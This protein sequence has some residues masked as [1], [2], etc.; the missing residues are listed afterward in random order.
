MLRPALLGLALV[1][2]G[3]AADRA[4]DLRILRAL[5]QGDAGP[6]AVI[7]V[8][9]DR[10]I[11]ASL[12][13]VTAD[14]T[15]ILHI[16]PMVSGLAEWRDPVTLQFTPSAPLAA[17]TSYH[18]TIDTGFRAMDG[19]RLA[20]PYS[21][22]FR[23]RGPQLLAGIPAGPGRYGSNVTSLL[24]APS[25]SFYLV[26]GR[27]ISP[28]LI[29]R[30]TWF[31]TDRSCATGRQVIRS[32]FITT[33]AIDAKDRWEFREAGGYERD[34][35]ADS[36]RRV[37]VIQ[38]ATPLPLNCSIGLVAPP[39]FD[40]DGAELPG[41]YPFN[42][43]GPFTLGACG[44][45]CDAGPVGPIAINFSTPVRGAD[46]QRHVTV[47][48]ATPVAVDDTADVRTR[49]QITTDPLRP[50][51]GY[52]IVADTGLRDVFGQR[53]SG[54]PVTTAVTTGYSPSLEYDGGRMLVERN[55]Y[56]TL[57]VR[58]VNLDTLFLDARP[59]P[60][61]LYAE[62]LRRGPW[63]WSG[64]WNSL[65][66]SAG[67]RAV[68][69]HGDRD[70]MMITGLALPLSDA[71]RPGTA[72]AWAVKV[73]GNVP[74]EKVPNAWGGASVALVQ[75]TDLAVTSRAGGTEATI[76]VTGA[77]DGKPRTGARVEVHNGAG[78]LLAQGV[79]DSS[80]I[81]RFTGLRG[82]EAGAA[83]GEGDDGDCEEDCGG[84]GPA[85]GAYVA[86]RLGA[87]RALL[88]VNE[89]AYDLS[90]W[91][92][93][94]YSAY[95]IAKQQVAAAVFTER[96]IYRPGEPVYAKAIVRTGLLGSLTTPAG[97]SVKL[98]FNDR[99]GGVLRSTVFRL[100]EFGTASDS[101][102]LPADAKLGSYS[103]SAS[104]YRQG[105]WQEAGADQYR[106]AEYRAPEFVVAVA[107][108]TAARFPGDSTRTTVEARYLF[109]APMGRA[110]VHWTASLTPSWFGAEQI[111][112]LGDGWYL[113]A[114]GYWWEDDQPNGPNTTVT[115]EGS[116][117]LDATGHLTIRAPVGAP[118]KGH[119]GMFTVEATVTDVNRRSVAASSRVM[120]HPASFY[121]AAK[122]TGD[123]FWTGGTP[124]RIDVLAVRPDGRKVGG[125]AVQGT[126]IRRE[127]HQV[128][129]TRYGYSEVTGEWVE[130]TVARCALQT[131]ETP[132]SCA[133]TPS[134]G[135]SYIV[136]FTAKDAG[137]RD[138]ETSFYR[139]A[140]G[141]GWV[142]WNDENR[143]KLDIIPDKERYAPGDTATLLIASP[144]TNAEAWFTVEREG[145]IEQRRFR[146][147]DGATRIR[148]P[149]TERHSPNVFVSVVVVRGRSG[150]PGTL[151]D[152]G[153]P[154]LR[155]GYAQLRV[156][157][158]V[159]RLTVSVDPGRPE[160]R[161]GDTASVKVAVRSGQNGVRSEVTLWAVDEGVL[162][163]TGFK[164][165]D[166]LDRIY[167][168]RGLGLTLSSGLVNVAPQVLQEVSRQLKGLRNAGQG[169]GRE[170]ADVLR[171]KFQTTAFFLG[172][173]V[174][175]AD[176]KGSARVKL[177]DN[178]TTFRVMA[179]AVTTGDRYG[180]GE[181]PLLVTRPLLARPSLPRFF[182]P[183]DQF[184][185][186]VVVNQR[187]G[188]TP[189]VAVDVAATGVTL[190]G[191]A[192]QSATLEAGRGK[193]V[194]FNFTGTGPDSGSFR[195]DV[196]GGGD[197]DAVRTRLPMRPDFHPRATTVAG[198]LN[199]TA[200]VTITL[201]AG[202]DPARTRLEFST[203]S[204][205][206]AILRGLDAELRL[207]D[208]LCTEQAVSTARPLLELW[209]A[210]QI[211]GDSLVRSDARDRLVRAIGMVTRRQREDGA[212]ALWDDHNGW[213]SP[214]LTSYA[215]AFLADA[216][217][218]GLPVDQGVLDKAASW[219]GQQAKGNRVYTSPVAYWLTDVKAQLRERL[220]AADFVSRMGQPDLATEN[221]LVRSVALLS[222]ED[223]VRLAQVLARRNAMRNAR[224]I[225]EP[226]WRG[227]RVEGSRA[228]VP[229]SIDR[230]GDFYFYSHVRPLARLLEATLAVDTTNALIGPMVQTLVQR[231][232]AERA[233]GW[234]WWW[235][236]QD[237][238]SAA[239]ALAAYG[240]RQ[241]AAAGRGVTVTAGG[242]PFLVFAAGDTTV[243][244]M[245]GAPT[246]LTRVGTDS[247]RLTLR[248]TAGGAGAGLFYIVTA[249]EAPKSQPVTPDDRGIRVERWYE[250]LN[251]HT[252]IGT[253]TE[254]ELVRVKVRVTTTVERQFV[255]V[256]DP[257]PAGFEAV[258]LS[259]ATEG[260]AGVNQDCDS[261]TRADDENGTPGWNWWYGE[262][263]GC[264]WSPFDHKEL[265]DD[266]VVWVASILWPGTHTLSYIARATTPGTY[267][268]STAWAEEMYNPG[269]NGRTEGGIFTVRQR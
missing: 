5:P 269:V 78:K 144:I 38:P 136:R 137:G 262:W 259:L 169:G 4:P 35:R 115:A 141:R 247:V 155:V 212:I 104:V 244:R 213:T 55:G 209:K 231:G 15:K 42:T 96:D 77:G 191:A 30:M 17:G 234:W 233:Q 65:D 118:P 201:P 154:T 226:I 263:E 73:R 110:A 175:G 161:P 23:I 109:G 1:A 81:A 124:Q 130:D 230:P 205:P 10:P 70:Q 24:V 79:T 167:A 32:R 120:V 101:L 227:V 127:W 179:V 153:R 125:V 202:T 206:F 64:V 31:E 135:G 68:P 84:G 171:S 173:V 158:E 116:D 251:A 186:G 258:D 71:T 223:R 20:A 75:V 238:A 52:A 245:V 220:A 27:G 203:G 7:T 94:V 72:T 74:A 91:Q 163:L 264:Y 26:I 126:I 162:S 194:R 100:S 122:P 6:L 147:T 131:A 29:G 57:A 229:D 45:P 11:A 210:Q 76:W 63:G 119:P 207:Y 193:E 123:Y 107:G 60:D 217:Q 87:D 111:P 215:A 99:D 25:D 41:R 145:I 180:S 165:P 134:D 43:Y 257:L 97:D 93:N 16:V 181:A 3:V 14:P 156:T 21:F 53:L 139:W 190:T 12:E 178:L 142:P 256:E 197:R 183:G 249:F 149:I 19:A 218:A 188:G 83:A 133:I 253:V 92:F 33:R 36:L 66:S 152:P 114:T 250:P 86:V 170:A 18:V 28:A 200:T 82:L 51:T 224:T 239:S 221:E 237:V 219:L 44:T 266:R 240:R 106:V 225:L 189:T 192:H 246:L 148:L 260:R 265:R 222:W 159:K 164:T 39:F 34:R 49:W 113:G 198:V 195:F 187:A 128:S 184:L 143:F 47:L 243:D 58:H 37:V 112:G 140:T 261:Y 185:A 54:N 129:R 80:G 182:R 89:S 13:G 90:P 67:V 105:S 95:G 235:N 150:A 228:V 61:S 98:T 40:D 204:S 174:T 166:P 56:R 46:V 177:P 69:V 157:P 50:R 121:I 85:N 160:Y 216:K 8:S 132:V 168:E 117:T 252:P 103:V 268:R 2:A 59:V 196:A 138:V 242:R 214:W 22:D 146:I 48:P 108:D 211:G 267:K 62:M 199:D 255:V 232:R 208:W 172:S 102:M 254:G 88:G 176:G 248:L 9:F 236:T 241:A 151:D